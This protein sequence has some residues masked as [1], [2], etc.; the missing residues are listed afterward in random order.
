MMSRWNG[1][2]TRCGRRSQPTLRPDEEYL[3]RTWLLSVYPM[4]KRLGANIILPRISPQPHTRIWRSEGFQFAKERGKANEYH[5]RVMRAF[6]TEEQDIGKINVL[7]RLAGEL[8]LDEKDF[9]LALETRRYKEPHQRALH[10]A[11]IEAG[12]NSVPTFLIAGKRLVGTQTREAL[13]RAI[14]RG[15]EREG[16]KE[17]T[18]DEATL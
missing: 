18:R 7:T 10:Y 6:F 1:C 17:A 8:E 3:R 9:K 13:E 12:I 5:R 11:R 2:P 4:A 16:E 14:G 15:L